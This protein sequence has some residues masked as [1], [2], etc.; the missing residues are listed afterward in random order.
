[1]GDWDGG[2]GGEGYEAAS[3]SRNGADVL[4]GGAVA[5]WID[6]DGRRCGL[7]VQVIADG[8]WM[9]AWDIG[10]AGV[11]PHRWGLGGGVRQRARGYG[12]SPMGNG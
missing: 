10:G 3:C 1:M 4:G 7:L 5:T 9:A 2:V 11:G 8:D 12:L 6:G